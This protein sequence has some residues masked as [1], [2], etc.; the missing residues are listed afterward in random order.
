MQF[1]QA[2][3]ILFLLALYRAVELQ[4]ELEAAI[5]VLVEEMAVMEAFT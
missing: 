4:E 1:L 2:I 5:Q 3:H